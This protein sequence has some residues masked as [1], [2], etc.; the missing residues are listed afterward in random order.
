MLL[1][2]PTLRYAGVNALLLQNNKLQAFIQLPA[3]NLAGAVS[4][5]YSVS[6][7]TWQVSLRLLNMARLRPV[8]PPFMPFNPFSITEVKKKR[9]GVV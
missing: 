1:R 7:Q 6:Q 2:L 4:L 5:F 3:Y 8:L 9:R